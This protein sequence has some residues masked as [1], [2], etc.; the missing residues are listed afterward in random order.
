[1]VTQSI[2]LR[3]KGSTQPVQKL[4]SDG[5]PRK[6]SRAQPVPV[7]PLPKRD[8]YYILH[9]NIR[10]I[11]LFDFHPEESEEQRVRD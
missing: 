2:Q 8:G 1:M 3:G 11:R 4:T 10:K 9:W 6:A 5:I 7:V